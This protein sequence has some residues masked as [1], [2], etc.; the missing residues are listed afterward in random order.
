[1]VDL[2]DGWGYEP[3]KKLIVLLNGLG[4]KEISEIHRAEDAEILNLS[5]LLDAQYPFNMKFVP[6]EMLLSRH[7]EA[8]VEKLVEWVGRIGE[9]PLF[10]GKNIKQ[11]L[12]TPYGFSL[13]WFN[14]LQYKLF[15]GVLFDSPLIN[16][17]ILRELMDGDAYEECLVYGGEPKQLAQIK[18]YLRD[19]RVR[20]VKKPMQVKTAE[21]KM[22][23]RGAI[24]SLAYALIWIKNL[25]L[26][27]MFYKKRKSAD[28]HSEVVF[29]GLHPGSLIMSKQE[30]IERYYGDLPKQLASEGRRVGFVS[31]YCNM[32]EIRGMFGRDFITAAARFPQ[33]ITFLET[34]LSI[35][36]VLLKYGEYLKLSYKFWRLPKRAKADLFLLDSADHSAW[37]GSPFLSSLYSHQV[38]YALLINEAT[39][40][41]VSRCQPKVAFTCYVVNHAGRAFNTGVRRTGQNVPIIG[42]QHASYPKTKAEV[43]YHKSEID[44]AG[45]GRDMVSFA[46]FAD[47][48]L[49]QGKMTRDQFIVAGLPEER[50]LQIGSPR[51]DVLYNVLRDSSAKKDIPGLNIPPG[52]K[53]VVVALSAVP[54]DVTQLLELLYRAV[55]DRFFL[56]FKPHP[57]MPIGKLLAQKAAGHPWIHYSISDASVYDLIARCDILVTSHSTVAEEA[58]AMGKPAIS[59]HAGAYIN[60]AAS[61]SLG[62]DNCA[63]NTEEL[64]RKIEKM[65]SLDPEEFGRMREKVIEQCFGAL[66]GKA[67]KRTADLIREKMGHAK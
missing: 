13:W 24:F 6:R 25:I 45:G 29:F 47:Y 8:A 39:F 44:P 46:P 56:I 37:L 4:P 33:P 31:A 11:L 63:H 43:R 57:N 64:K 20:F 14:Q 1:M 61:A 41:Y 32:K 55:D 30:I 36:E 9:K 28:V 15:D 10:E 23:L 58:I 35:R 66:D 34:Q 19:D 26:I 50:C 65:L 16:A 49:V 42:L 53:V 22:F 17:G 60:I 59:V 7:Q 52:K 38:L 62:I 67:T 18:E 12:A 5:D 27:K 3:M 51:F 48:F 54:H 21:W 40:K 2:R